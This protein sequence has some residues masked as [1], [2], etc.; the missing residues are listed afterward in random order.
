MTNR[1]KMN[2][3][4]KLA[5]WL[6]I[7][8]TVLLLLG[9]FILANAPGYSLVS[10]ASSAA[11]VDAFSQSV[12]L[13]TFLTFAGAIA[14]GVGFLTLVPSLIVGIILLKTKTQITPVQKEK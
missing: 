2:S 9:G 1:P 8:P 5:L 3:R 6:L 12:P 7:T 11:S 13:R 14:T 10:E 4:K